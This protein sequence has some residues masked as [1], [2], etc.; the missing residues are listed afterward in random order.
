VNER[1]FEPGEAFDASEGVL[2]SGELAK[3]YAVDVKTAS[4]WA[5]A[6]KVPHIRTPGGHWRFSRAFHRRH[7]EAEAGG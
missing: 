1:R 6:G 2:T 4:R 7:M 5:T 3:T